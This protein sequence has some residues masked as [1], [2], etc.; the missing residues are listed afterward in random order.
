[1]QLVVKNSLNKILE[2]IRNGKKK[3]KKKKKK[4]KENIKLYL[5]ELFSYRLQYVYFSYINITV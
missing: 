1:M 5:N 2:S 4:E 3:K